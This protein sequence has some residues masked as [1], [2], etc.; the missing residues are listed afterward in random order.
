[1]ALERRI[2]HRSSSLPLYDL[3]STRT[4][5]NESAGDSK[6]KTIRAK[7]IAEQI[8]TPSASVQRR[9]SLEGQR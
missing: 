3:D 1:M 8:Y 2:V 9:T 6:G 7:V 4:G 5:W